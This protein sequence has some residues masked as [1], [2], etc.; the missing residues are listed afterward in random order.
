MGIS[1]CTSGNPDRIDYAKYWYHEDP[2]PKLF[3][4]LPDFTPHVIH[5][6]YMVVL[7]VNL[8]I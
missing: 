4:G 1:F 6:A 8:I 2:I 3:V 7:A 5:S